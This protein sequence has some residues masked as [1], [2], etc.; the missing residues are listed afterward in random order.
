MGSGLGKRGRRAKI[1]ALEEAFTGRFTGHHAFLLTKMPAHDFGRHVIPIVR[2]E[3]A[4]LDREGA[5]AFNGT[6][7]FE[8]FSDRVRPH[9]PGLGALMWYGGASLRQ[10][11]WTGEHGTNF[12]ISSVIKSEEPEDFPQIQLSHIR[13]LRA[14]H[15]DGERARVSQGLVVIPTDSATPE[16]RARYKEYAG[17]SAYPAPPRRR[18]RHRMSV[19]AAVHL[20]PRGLREDPHRHRYQVGARARPASRVIAAVTAVRPGTRR[21][22]RS[23]RARRPRCRG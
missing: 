18:V 14:H 6:E 9:S 21:G 22:G 20:R 3:V 2:E 8:V 10:G 16:Q 1:N 23:P 4:G 12:L 5:T 13:E 19:R 17:A 7:G 15:P 11:R